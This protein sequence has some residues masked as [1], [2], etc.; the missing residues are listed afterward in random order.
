[1]EDIFDTLG[2]VTMFDDFLD[3][4][5]MSKLLYFYMVL[6]S[7]TDGVCSSTWGIARMIGANRNAVQELVEAGY[8]KMEA[9]NCYQILALRRE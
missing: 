6:N 5:D 8:I 3:L 9:Q 2:I 7:D 1:M 4:E